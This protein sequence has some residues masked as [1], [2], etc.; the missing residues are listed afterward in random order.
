MEIF[1]RLCNARE[2]IYIEYTVS[3]ALHLK[4]FINLGCCWDMVMVTVG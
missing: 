1:Y 2:F 3:F 4:M